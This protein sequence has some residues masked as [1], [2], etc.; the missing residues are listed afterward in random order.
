MFGLKTLKSGGHRNR[1]DMKRGIKTEK[2]DDP[3][4]LRA[5]GKKGGKWDGKD[6]GRWMLTQNYQQIKKQN[7]EIWRG[8]KEE[9]KKGGRLSRGQCNGL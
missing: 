5:Q 4:G 8:K 1:G 9:I 6:K 2:T 7:G 3:R